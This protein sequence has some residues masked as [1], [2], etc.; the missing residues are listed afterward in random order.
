MRGAIALGG[1]I[2]SSVAG[3][4]PSL[5][6]GSTFSLLGVLLGMVGG[7]AGIAAVAKVVG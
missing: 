3:A 7:I 2:G 5:W 1:L 4:I 6:G